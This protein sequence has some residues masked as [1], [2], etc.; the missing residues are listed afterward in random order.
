MEDGTHLVGAAKELL[1]LP[2]DERIR[3]ILRS[4]WV[5]YDRARQII[6]HMEYLLAHPRTHRM[7]CLLIVGDTNN[8]KTA[9]V[10][11]FLRAH[12]PDDNPEGDSAVIPV[13]SVQ[14]PPTADEGRFYEEIL[15][16][17]SAPFRHTEKANKKQ[18]QVLT[19]LPA[20]GVQM[21]IVDE[22][23]DILAGS[24]TNQRNFRNTLKQLSNKLRIPIVGV[25]T[26]EALSAVQ[27]DAQLA[28]RFEPMVLSKWQV[29]DDH[30]AFLAGFESTLPLKKPSGLGTNT[31]L[32]VKLCAMSGG[33]LG[34]LSQILTRAAVKAIE[35]K[36]EMIDA[37]LLDQITFQPLDT[38]K[39]VAA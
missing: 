17:L 18:H 32:E 4:R 2:D 33:L 24:K 23:H 7:P 37:K 10:E 13:L 35:T 30:R 8:G 25:G 26:R 12:P 3:R 14:A 27:S 16:T 22:I 38:R 6:A 20:V 39:K 36:K 28:N 5:P 34:E 31:S 9:I 29:G 21:L 19:L 11:K 15:V 1:A